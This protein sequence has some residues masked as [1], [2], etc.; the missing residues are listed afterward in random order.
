MESSAKPGGSLNANAAPAGSNLRWAQKETI[1]MRNKIGL[2]GKRY[3]VH[4]KPW[5]WN[6]AETDY[7]RILSQDE[8]DALLRGLCGEDD[9]RAAELRR[10]QDENENLSNALLSSQDQLGHCKRQAAHLE[11]QL[12][13]AQSVAGGGFWG[14]LKWL[15]RG[16]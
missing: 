15:V 9:P 12:S 4:P 3:G 6:V 10:L 2:T 13:E 5:R 16:K 1:K 8:V 7:P 11:A 14:R